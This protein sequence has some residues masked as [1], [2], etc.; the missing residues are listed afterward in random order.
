MNSSKT[1]IQRA[2]LLFA[3]L[4]IS[5]KIILD[6]NGKEWN[7]FVIP[8]KWGNKT[9][10]I[11]ATDILTPDEFKIML[12][13]TAKVIPT[14]EITI[15]KANS[16]FRKYL[17]QRA[18]LLGAI[19]L[20][21]D[22]FK[23]NAGTEVTSDIIFLQKRDKILDIEPDWVNIGQT[24]DGVAVNKYFEDNLQ[25]ILGKMVSGMS[26]YG[27]S[28]ETSCEPI[29]G[30]VLSEQLKESRIEYSRQHSRNPA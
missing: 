22:A 15:D 17:A 9:N 5:L 27:N 1:F 30:A 13:V 7:K 6:T 12:S 11:D 25:M 28:E 19:R 26:M 24:V 3:V 29:E 18:E 8:D 4:C 2:Y 23:A 16:S 21:N 20:P 14:E 10:S